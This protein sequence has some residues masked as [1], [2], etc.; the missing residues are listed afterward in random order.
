METWEYKAVSIDAHTTWQT[1]LSVKRP[2]LADEE[3]EREVNRWGAEG[4]ECISLVPGEW[5]GG[6]NTY[7]VTTYHALFKRPKA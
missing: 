4:W 6:V 7:T 2:E 1:N 5:R 3:L